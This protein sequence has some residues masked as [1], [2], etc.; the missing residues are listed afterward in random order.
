MRLRLP[1][2]ANQEPFTE[3]MCTRYCADDRC[4][5]MSASAPVLLATV[6]FNS[7]G[8][9]QKLRQVSALEVGI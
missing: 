9:G 5:D 3:H 8:A 6:P 4:W 7:G 1:N 2:T